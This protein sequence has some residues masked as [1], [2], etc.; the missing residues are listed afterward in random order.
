MFLKHGFW[1]PRE[2]YCP[3]NRGSGCSCIMGGEKRKEC[4]G[5]QVRAYSNTHTHT[6]TRT[7]THTHAYSSYLSGLDQT[8]CPFYWEWWGQKKK[9]KYYMAM[10]SML[11]VGTAGPPW[12]AAA[13]AP[14]CWMRR[15]ARRNAVRPTTSRRPGVLKTWTLALCSFGEC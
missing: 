2:K 9:D 1:V 4:D 15:L 3:K 14:S 5:L 11:Q 13:A 12:Y 6:H 7:H 10:F 8:Y